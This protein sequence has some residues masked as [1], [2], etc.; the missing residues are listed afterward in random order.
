M[1]FKKPIVPGGSF[2]WEEYAW[3]REFKAYGQPTAAQRNNAVFLFTELEP[4]RKELGKPLII[5]SGARTAEYTAHLRRKGIPAAPR[6]A[7]NEWK[8]VDLICPGMKT[9]E[10]W[11][12][13]DKRWKG[14]MEA[15]EA[16]PTWVHLDTRDYGKR[17]RFKP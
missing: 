4:L 16:T 2:T 6:S 15:L 7:H 8:A 1:D 9:P 5:T 12:W 14:R 10:L 11:K 17:I 3:L 13:F